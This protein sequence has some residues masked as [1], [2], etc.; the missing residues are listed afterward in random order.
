MTAAKYNTR[1]HKT[2]RLYWTAVIRAGNGQCAEPK[3]VKPSRYIAP[4]G[5]WHVCHD[6][7]GTVIIGPGHRGCNIAEVNQRR[8]R[9]VRASRRW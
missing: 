1:E 8:A 9:P 4:G 6:P 5:P 7:S 2:A 3:C